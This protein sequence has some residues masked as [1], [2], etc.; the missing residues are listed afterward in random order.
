MTTQPFP[1]HMDL[2]DIHVLQTKDT[3]VPLVFNTNAHS[4]KQMDFMRFVIAVALMGQC[5][6]KEILNT[7]PVSES[8][9]F[10]ICH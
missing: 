1:E 2:K 10:L 4:P 6:S 7:R 3:R 9:S 8:L 5:E